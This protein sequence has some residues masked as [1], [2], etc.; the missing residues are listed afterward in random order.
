MPHQQA[1]RYNVLRFTRLTNAAPE[2]SVG[3]GSGILGQD[4]DREVGVKALVSCTHFRTVKQPA[5]SMRET[6]LSAANR[7]QL[8]HS[9]APL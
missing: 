2:R 9:H 3:D 4:G 1:E 6:V 8:A 5:F 7:D